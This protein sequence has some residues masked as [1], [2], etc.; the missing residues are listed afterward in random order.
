VRP[1]VPRVQPQALGGW[2]SAILLRVI[3]ELNHVGGRV[4]DLDASLAFYTGLAATIAHPNAEDPDANRLIFVP[5]PS[6]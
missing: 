6:E 2:V 3:Y 5:S 1:P 4:R